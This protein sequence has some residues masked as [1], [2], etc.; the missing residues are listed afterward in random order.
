M[1]ALGPD[2][3]RYTSLSHPSRLDSFQEEWNFL[4]GEANMLEACQGRT[5]GDM[6]PYS[7]GQP[8]LAQKS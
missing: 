6:D 1:R 5:E 8:E 4:L 2:D 3:G 7:G